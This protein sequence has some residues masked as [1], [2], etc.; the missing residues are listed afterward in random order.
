MKIQQFAGCV[1]GSLLLNSICPLMVSAETSGLHTGHFENYVQYENAAAVGRLTAV[2]ES[3]AADITEALPAAYDL[4]TKGLVSSVKNQN[5]YG[6]CWSFSAVNL[7]ENQLIDR[8][9]DID[10]SEWQLAYYTY[11]PIFGFPL[12]PNTDMDDVFQ[13]GGSYYT[14]APMLTSW[15][16]PVSEKFFPFDDF[17]VLNPDA[18]WSAIKAQTEYHVSDINLCSYYIEDENFQN[19]ADAVKQAVYQGNAVSVSYYN[20]NNYY[21]KNKY[22]YYNGSNTKTGGNYHA[23]SIIGWDDNFPAG[24]FLTEPE[25]DGAWLVKN[26]WGADW[27]DCGYFWLSYYDPT[28]LEFYYLHTEPFQK[29]DKIYQHDDYG[30]W[31]AFS[32]EEADDSA[33]M[34]NVFTAEEDTYLT[35]V[36]LCTAMPEEQYTIRIY[37]NLKQENNPSSGTVKSGYTVGTVSEAGYH[38]IDLEEPVEL[39]AGETFSVVVKLSGKSGQHLAGELYTESTVIKTDGTISSESSMLTEEMIFRNFHKGE[40]FYSANG[41][42]WYDVYEEE[43]LKEEYTAEDGS[44]FSDYSIMGN[45]CVRALTKQAGTVI[46]SEDAEALPAGTEIQLS[47]SGSSEIYYC[48]NNGEE[49]LYTEPILMPEEEITISACAVVNGEKQEICEK[50]YA[51]QEAV[52]SSLY[53]AKGK[54]KSYL[55]FEKTDTQ[56]YTAFCKPL[57]KDETVACMPVSTGEIFYKE[58]QL[59]SGVLT[60]VEPDETGKITLHVSQAGR[61]ETVYEICFELCG[62]ADNNRVINAADAAKILVYA[63]QVGSGENPELPDENFLLRGDYH[64]DGEVNALDAADILVYAAE[65]G[66]LTE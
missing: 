45:L 26:S 53:L 23:V 64:P 44:E 42:T 22:C 66:A 15:T 30:Y 58:E 31:S 41:R 37:K 43:P 50:T 13:Q 49:M 24:D 36:M 19:Q 16:A 1:L 8:N 14:V 28:M 35:S 55:Q 62:D 9:P 59:F 25:Q 46:F 3:L 61:K 17:S 5:P 4:R 21:N 38:T 54:E 33:Y 32:I 6:M 51:M 40:S 7:I 18:D 12:R 60:P 29:H 47:S 63:A 52:L 57:A 65:Q 48:I 11:S 27:G 20:K 56:Q 10:L 2:N 34:A 39:L